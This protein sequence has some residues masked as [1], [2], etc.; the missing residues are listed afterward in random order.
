MSVLCLFPPWSCLNSAPSVRRR[1]FCMKSATN[2]GCT[3]WPQKH[4]L[5]GVS[6]HYLCGNLLRFDVDKG[7]QK[8]WFFY[9]SC[10]I[11]I[12]TKCFGNG[13][14]FMYISFISAVK[15]NMNTFAGSSR[16]LWLLV[17]FLYFFFDIRVRYGPHT[18]TSY[19]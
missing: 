3:R 8:V 7:N 16:V 1:W 6:S 19:E 2:H 14:L 9:K 18:H 15:K 17:F 12:Y 13:S 4:C 5:F 10:I 11:R